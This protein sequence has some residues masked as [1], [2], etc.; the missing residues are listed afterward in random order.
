MSSQE[1]AVTM[2]DH[3]NA[4]LHTSAEYSIKAQELV[5]SGSVADAKSLY[6]SIK[7]E[8]DPECPNIDDETMEFLTFV[9][10]VAE[11]ES[12]SGGRRGKR[13]VQ[14]GGALMDSI[15][16]FF[17]SLCGRTD[18]FAKTSDAIASA[19]VNALT[20]A[21]NT[22]THNTVRNTIISLLSAGGAISMMLTG[23][24]SVARLALVALRFV[25]S[26]IPSPGFFIYNTATGLAQWIPVV[27]HAAQFGVSLYTMYSCYQAIMIANELLREKLTKA[28]E[29]NHTEFMKELSRRIF[30][31]LVY[32]VTSSLQGRINYARNTRAALASPGGGGG[33]GGGNGPVPPAP[34]AALDAAITAAGTSIQGVVDAARARQ[35][36]E[37]TDGQAAELS[38]ALDEALDEE[39]ERGLENLPT[40]Q[41]SIRSNATGGTTT[42]E[43]TTGLTFVGSNGGRVRPPRASQGIPAVSHAAAGAAYLAA[44]RGRA[45]QPTQRARESSRSRPPRRGVPSGGR[46]RVTRKTKAKRRSR[47]RTTRR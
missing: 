47:S 46:R 42:T 21:V 27:P 5:R 20:R 13:K 24:N 36:I 26:F 44:E 39:D 19:R 22:S 23:N 30:S 6:S 1:T 2:E 12:Q 9:A 15:G 33:G 41:G 3:S 25:N 7:A 38:A 35:H 45:A 17:R 8:E 14:R 11:G 31:K 28:A 37:I 4:P 16:N 40:P 32:G 10:M 43:G 34:P 29:M 18:R